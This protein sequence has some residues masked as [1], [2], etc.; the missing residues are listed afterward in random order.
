MKEGSNYLSRFGFVMPVV[1]TFIVIFSLLLLAFLY[2]LQT[3]WLIVNRALYFKNWQTFSA[4]HLAV[5]DISTGRYKGASAGYRYNSNFY[6]GNG[7]QSCGTDCWQVTYKIPVEF[8]HS[9]ISCSSIDLTGNNCV[10][11]TS[12][13]KYKKV[14]VEYKRDSESGRMVIVVKPEK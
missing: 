8:S 5:H 6:E 4:I 2:A 9:S 10:K 13:E 7:W 1:L 11:I 14:S 3:G 12:V